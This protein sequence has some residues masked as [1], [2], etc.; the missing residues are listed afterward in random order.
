MSYTRLTKEIN[1]DGQKCISCALYGT[2]KCRIHKL[3]QLDSFSGCGSC[4]VLG[5]M[6]NSLYQF[7]EVYTK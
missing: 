3:G 5:A 2:D 1:V 7:E 6:L 4:D